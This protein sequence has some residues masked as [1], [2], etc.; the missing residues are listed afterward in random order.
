MIISFVRCHAN[1]HPFRTIFSLRK[2]TA[3]HF[4]ASRIIPLIGNI[5]SRELTNPTR[6][7]KENHRLKSAFERRYVSFQ[8]GTYSKDAGSMSLSPSRK[9]IYLSGVRSALLC[10]HEKKV[11]ASGVQKRLD[12]SNKYI[13]FILIYIYMLYEHVY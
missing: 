3:S 2:N 8:Q 12:V 4:G 6:G 5:P 1:Q 9:T 10:P 13:K 7:E 11:I